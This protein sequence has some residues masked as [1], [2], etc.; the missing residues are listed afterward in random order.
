MH[1]ECFSQDFF[2]LEQIHPSLNSKTPGNQWKWSSWGAMRKKISWAPPPHQGKMGVCGKLIDDV[3]LREFPS[4][5]PSLSHH[6]RSSV[7]PSAGPKWRLLPSFCSILK[8]S[9]VQHLTLQSVW[10]GVLQLLKTTWLGEREQVSTRARA[11][12]G[13]K[14]SKRTSEEEEQ[15]TGN[16]VKFNEA[17]Q[18]FAHF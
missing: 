17:F 14:E 8:S 15:E 16:S 2:F 1:V 12:F 5:T 6:G 3:K 7:L 11:G 4:L 10:P 13:A 18:D 9:A